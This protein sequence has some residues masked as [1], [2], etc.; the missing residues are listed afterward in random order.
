LHQRYY[1]AI[2]WEEFWSYVLWRY[3]PTLA[4]IRLREWE[5]T[6]PK[7]ELS[8]EKVINLFSSLWREENLEALR[9][10]RFVAQ[11]LEIQQTH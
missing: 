4:L 3:D 7:E 8:L 2:P 9:K 10:A 6:N 1:H 11:T 5:R